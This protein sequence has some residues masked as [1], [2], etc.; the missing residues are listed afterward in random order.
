MTDEL[1]AARQ[2]LEAAT[3]EAQHLIN[4]RIKELTL[5]G[6]S[7]ET[8]AKTLGCSMTRVRAVRKSAGV[9]HPGH[10]HKRKVDPEQL[11]RL[12][13]A[14]K[15]T[16]ELAEVFD[17]HPIRIREARREAGLPPEPRKPPKRRID[18]QQVK[19]RSEAGD[20][21]ASIAEALGCSIS[22]IIKIRHE[23]GIS[24]HNKA[25]LT[26]DAKRRIEAMLDDGCSFAEITRTLGISHETLKRHYHGRQW[27]KEQQVEH[28]RTVRI[29]K[30]FN[31]GH[32]QREK[33]A[34]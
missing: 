22:S 12:I 6:K 27:T 33:S 15:T 2:R 16:A 21:L 23:L 20:T 10:H 19:A 9:Q 14:G 18:P 24:D 8:I 1:A 28:L 26:E 32:Q 4:E 34:A 11:I 13:E 7:V 29:E 30:R 5:E 3:H 31:W 17:C 25:R